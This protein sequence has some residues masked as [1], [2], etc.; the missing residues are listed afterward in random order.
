MRIAVIDL[1]TNTF[2]MIIVDVDADKHIKPVYQK[3][4]PAKLG[5]GGI[6]KNEISPEAFQRGLV[7]LKEHAGTITQFDVDKTIAIA[8]SAIRS[9]KNG[10]DFVLQAQT[11]TGI[12]IEVIDGDRE[13]DLIFKGVSQLMPFTHEYNL[14]LDIGGG[15]CEFILANQEGVK[16]RKSYDLGM[17]RLLERFDFSDPVTESEIEEVRAYLGKELKDFIA[18]MTKY[19]LKILTGTSGSFDALANMVSQRFHQKPLPINHKVFS[20]EPNQLKEL[21]NLMFVTTLSQKEDIPGMDLIRIEMIV[22]ACIFIQ[23]VIDSLGIER[24][25]QSPYAIKQGAIIEAFV[26]GDCEG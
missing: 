7:F 14:V 9:A 20:I 3:K 5:K 17:A 16:F 22:P 4:L 8:T 19:P 13:A 12:A 6:N 15:S 25:Y 21:I 23:F 11:E 1:G 24:I 26:K 10:R 18:E 2:N